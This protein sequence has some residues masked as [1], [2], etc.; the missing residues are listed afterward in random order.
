MGMNDIAIIIRL[1]FGALTTFFAILLSSR[2]RDP[3]LIFIIIGAVFM[4]VQIVLLTL[5]AFGVFDVNLALFGVPSLL[6]IAIENIPLVFLS[7]GFILAISAR[8]KF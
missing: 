1:V 6:R 7:T 5:D 8:I 2:T 4:Y 3:A